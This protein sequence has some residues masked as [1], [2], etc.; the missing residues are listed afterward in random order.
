MKLSKLLQALYFGAFMKF[1]LTPEEQATADAATASKAA[2]DAA[3][4]AVAAAEAEAA[5][6]L[7]EGKPKPTDAEAALLKENM[8]KKAALKKADEDKII[9]EAK[10]K[11]FEGID[12]EAVR[13]LLADK[14][15]ADT[16]QLEEKGDWERLKTRMGEEHAKDLKAALDRA[17]NFEG[18]LSKANNTINDLTI[19]TKFGQSLFI[20]DELI[21]TPAKARVI[22]ADNF[23]LVDGE[24]VGFDKPRSAANRTALVD[25]SGNPVAFDAALR[26]IIEAD[27]EK[28][29]LLKSK[30]K[31]GASSAS[32]KGSAAA[33]AA[34]EAAKKANTGSIGKISAGLAGLK[35][36]TN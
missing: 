6:L 3:T 5:R 34:S 28:D 22:Y 35:I 26:K 11:L 2:A 24:V 27:P 1:N 4:D 31:P 33:L 17:Q 14:A 9:L 7:A 30:V 23:D 10:L 8:Q 36:Q 29:Q 21:L 25:G 20:T 15:A 19:G 12:P 18:D 32:Q 16:K 13:K